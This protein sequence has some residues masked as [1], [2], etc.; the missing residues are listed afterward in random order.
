M[1]A[2]IDKQ[3]DNEQAVRGSLFEI[4]FIPETTSVDLQVVALS[5]NY[6]AH[7]DFCF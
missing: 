2:F 5:Q 7:F 1:I 4:Q 3:V 6:L